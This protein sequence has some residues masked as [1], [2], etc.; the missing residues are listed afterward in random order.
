[1]VVGRSKRASFHDLG[2]DLEVTEKNGFY[3]PFAYQST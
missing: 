1:V 2:L 3:S